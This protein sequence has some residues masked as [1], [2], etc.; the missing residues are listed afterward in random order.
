MNRFLLAVDYVLGLFQRVLE[1]FFVGLM[2]AVVL[3]GVA[4][5]CHPN[6][7][8]ICQHL[9]QAASA[10]TQLPVDPAQARLDASLAKLAAS[11]QQLV[12]ERQQ[13]QKPSKGYDPK[14]DKLGDSIRQMNEEYD[15]LSFDRHLHR[16]GD[17]AY[18]RAARAAILYQAAH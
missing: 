18:E 11:V 13:A 1:Y 6:S 12:D 7:D 14:N 17:E 10:F 2:W 15:E 9:D 5:L 8:R 16:L 4:I 3:L